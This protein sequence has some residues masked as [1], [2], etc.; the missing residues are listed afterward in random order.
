MLSKI[1]HVSCSDLFTVWVNIQ[2]QRKRQLTSL[3]YFCCALH[4]EKYYARPWV[5]TSHDAW[6]VLRVDR[7]YFKIAKTSNDDRDSYHTRFFY[8]SLNLS[9]GHLP[10]LKVQIVL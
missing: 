7:V 4:T 9:H 2:F 6:D 8:A 3:Q 1:P 5:R 10:S